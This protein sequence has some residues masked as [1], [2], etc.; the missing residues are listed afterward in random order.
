MCWDSTLR[1]KGSLSAVG[2]DSNREVCK[3]QIRKDTATVIKA[4]RGR[5]LSRGQQTQRYKGWVNFNILK[6]DNDREGIR[7]G[8]KRREGRK[9]D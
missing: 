7:G 3:G 5:W 9:G 4:S 8:G 6:V 2:T 1:V